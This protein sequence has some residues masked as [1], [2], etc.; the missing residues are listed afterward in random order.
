MKKETFTIKE[1]FPDMELDL[2]SALG[3]EVRRKY[4]LYFGGKLPAL[5]KENHFGKKSDVCLYP[6]KVKGFDWM[7]KVKDMAK[8]FLQ[9][10]QELIKLKRDVELEYPVTTKSLNP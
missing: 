9:K 1:L 3:R 8:E 6:T 2:R 7:G 4:S 5:T 10:E